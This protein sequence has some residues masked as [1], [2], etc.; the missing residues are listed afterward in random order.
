MMVMKKYILLEKISIENANAF[1]NIT[2]GIPAITGF[3]GF[4]HALERKLN[5][6]GVEIKFTGV[7][8]EFHEYELK[9]YRD[10]HGHYITTLPLPS[11]IPGKN[12][13][14]INQHV[15][16]QAYIDLTMSFVLEVDAEII[17]KSMCTTIKRVIES[18]RVAGGTINGYKDVKM[19]NSLKDIP[20]GY[21][22]VLRQDK[23]NEAFGSDM[24]DKM[25]NAM[26]NDSSLVPVAIG[27]KALTNVG[28]VEGQR[29]PEK[30]HCFVESVFSLVTFVQNTCLTSVDKYL[31]K[32]KAE[33]GVYLCAQE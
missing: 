14:E 21:F 28:Y 16:N 11:S 20:Y 19:I 26:Q 10:K 2:I 5:A 22:L 12:E 9:G 18:L 33:N 4:T 17:D 27:F 3:M 32:Y 15:M 13:K 6:K 25:I 7:G 31:W 30:E 24:L 1:N 23:L 29:D 8:I